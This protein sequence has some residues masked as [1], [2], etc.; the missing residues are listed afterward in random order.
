MGRLE[1]TLN[2]SRAQYGQQVSIFKSAGAE[3]GLG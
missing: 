3:K 2:L 1:K